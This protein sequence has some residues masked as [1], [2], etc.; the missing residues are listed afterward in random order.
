MK[1]LT[2]RVAKRP[3][4]EAPASTRT[5]RL[6]KRV[7]KKIFGTANPRHQVA[8]ILPGNQVGSVDLQFH[9]P[10]VDDLTALMDAVQRHPAGSQLDKADADAGVVA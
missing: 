4:P 5:A 3:S 6:P 8:I 10:A 7:L 1:K 9:T 2:L